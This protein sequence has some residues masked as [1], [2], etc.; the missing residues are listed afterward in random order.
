MQFADRMYNIYSLYLDIN[1]TR[2]QRIKKIMECG[3]IVFGQFLKYKNQ[4]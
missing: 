4:Y 3:L 2:I 1:T